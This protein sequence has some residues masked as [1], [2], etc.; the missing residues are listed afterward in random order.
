MRK[1]WPAKRLRVKLGV[2]VTEQ[3]PKPKKKARKKKQKK[4]EIEEEKQEEAK[5]EEQPQAEETEEVKEKEETEETTEEEAEEAKEE[6]TEEK[7]QETF[8]IKE[9]E[10]KI[11]GTVKFFNP[12][13]GFGFITG[14]DGKEYYFN[15]S[16]LKAGTSIEA[17]DR[18]SFKALESDKG[19][20]AEEVEKIVEE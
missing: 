8:G 10:E 16:E 2:G 3:V 18:V 19:P 11:K 14:D 20:K 4:Q 6:P 9:E 17:A 12:N 7:V 5:E 15:Q 13:K 1:P